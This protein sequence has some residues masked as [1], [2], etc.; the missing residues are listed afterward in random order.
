MKRKTTVAILAALAALSAQAAF[1]GDA[2]ALFEAKKTDDLLV[3][4]KI[5]KS[6]MIAKGITLTAPDIAE[7]AIMVPIKIDIDPSIKATRLLIVADKNPVPLLAVMDAEPAR[8]QIEIRV[9]LKESTEV[10]A[11]AI[12]SDGKAYAASKSVKVTIGG[13]GG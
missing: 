9:R 8:G 7:N 2:K 12:G 4:A 3:A 5:D 10:R 13:C 6:A 1:A 11:I